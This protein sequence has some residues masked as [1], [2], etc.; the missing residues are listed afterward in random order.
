MR[1]QLAAQERPAA[2]P[3]ADERHG[4][5]RHWES[6]A[7]RALIAALLLYQLVTGNSGGATVA[8]LGLALSLIP[9]LIAHFSHWQ[10]PR[11]LDFIFT[12]AMFLQFVSES[13]KLFEIFTYWDK[14]VHPSEIF[15]AT[16]VAT[17]LLLGYRHRH[18]LDIPD[19]LA[20]AGAMIFGMVLGASWE[21]VEFAL[22][23]FANANLQKSN[24]DTMT[25]ILTNDAGAIFGCLLAFW[26]WRHYT[27]T[28]QKEES[29]AIADWLTD[30]LA[31]LFGEHGF[32]VGVVVAL[33]VAGII[34]AG[35]RMDR[36]P[37]PPPPG[38]PGQPAAWQFAPGG[39]GVAGTAVVQGDWQTDAR[40]I[41]RVNAGSPRPGSE[42]MGL[43]ALEPGASYGEQGGYVLSAD[44]YAE[45]PPLGAGTAMATGL[46]FGVRDADDFYLL[47]LDA[48]HDTLALHRYLHGHERWVAEQ[49][50]RTR[51][52]EWHG[53]ELTVQGDRV[54]A[55]VDG[56]PVLDEHGVVDTVGGIALW[57]RVTTAG[58]FRDARVQP[59]AA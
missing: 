48:T 4:H 37:L 14:I 32:A 12:L 1:T 21:L 18:Q 20:A 30:R 38:A 58:C 34:F 16:G 27:T 46:A 2:S 26:W 54:A 17:F 22:D 39:S 55:A 53:L 9:P 51:G 31:R 47:E 23:W 45:R 42:K 13:L 41:C 36:E 33:V 50:L 15:L 28:Q 11:E 3:A 6:W 40:G 7:L 44:V 25:D 57:A 52:N 5:S 59:A 24:A 56:R 49:R 43:L 19:G 29:G 10:V 8:G 35:W